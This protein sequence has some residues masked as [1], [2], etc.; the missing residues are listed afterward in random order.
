MSAR[1]TGDTPAFSGFEPADHEVFGIRD[2]AK[3]MAAIRSRVTPKLTALGASLSPRLTAALGEPFFPHVA[4]HMRRTVNTPPE[5]W[6]AFGRDPR[7]YKMYAFL[8]VVASGRGVDVRLVLKDE[9][10]GDKRVL[11]DALD[12]ERT[13]LPDLFAATPDL[14]WYLGLPGRPR[15]PAEPPIAVGDLPSGFWEDLAAALRAR[16][17]SLV[18]IGVG[19]PKGDRLLAGPAFERTALR[20]MASLYPLYRLATAP[21]ATLSGKRRGSSASDASTAS[22]GRLAADRA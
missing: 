18:E 1:V 22:R 7:K 20:A 21:G 19:W 17:S 9:A 14:G 16:K 3:G 5:T 11:A 2:F 13:R 12:R 8:G 15:S 10:A 4:K 6:V